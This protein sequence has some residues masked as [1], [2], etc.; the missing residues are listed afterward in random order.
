MT[1]KAFD[2]VL[3]SRL[4][5]ALMTAGFKS[6]CLFCR[7]ALQRF[8]HIKASA[9]TEFRWNSVTLCPMSQG[10]S[11]IT[12]I[13]CPQL[14]DLLLNL[15]KHLRKGLSGCTLGIHS[16][17]FLACRL[18]SLVLVQMRLLLE[19]QDGRIGIAQRDNYK[20]RR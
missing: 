20:L 8:W 2:P 15:I 11:T 10:R 13:L 3:E 17:A 9:V 5:A 6:H 7:Q 1:G 12:V 4:S 18:L 16:A 19:N 14:A